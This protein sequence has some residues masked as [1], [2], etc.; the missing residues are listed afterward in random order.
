MRSNHN[1]S[2]CI[3]WYDERLPNT[4]NIDLLSASLLTYKLL[5]GHALR[6]LHETY[7]ETCQ[8]PMFPCRATLSW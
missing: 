1:E 8:S 3:D 4:I 7:V 5:S 2:Q 6:I